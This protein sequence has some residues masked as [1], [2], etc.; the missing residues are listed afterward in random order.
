MFTG[1]VE[2]RGIVSSVR[3]KGAGIELRVN[4]AI[5]TMDSKT[6]DSVS[7]NGACQTIEEISGAEFSVFVSSVTASVTTLSSFKAGSKVNLER[8]MRIDSRFG[9]HIVQGHVDGTGVIREIRKD[10]SGAYF[11]IS[12]KAEIMR[13]II[14]KGSVCV[15]GISL[16]V[17]LTENDY[18][19][20]YIIPETLRAT[21][22]GEWVPGEEVNIEC[23]VLAKYVE[24]L[25]GAEKTSD[26]GRGLE[27]ILRDEGYISR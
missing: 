4:S 6:G 10:P 11:R 22:A 25:F 26:N 24:K 9:G 13:Y 17:V 21:T 23:D 8:A 18:F 1:I 14:N 19:D 3:K 16:T 7:I 15:N 2:D 12:S 5:V 20:L 27:S